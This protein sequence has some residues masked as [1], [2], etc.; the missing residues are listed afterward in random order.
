M[1]ARRGGRCTFPQL[2]QAARG[3]GAP[4][5]ANTIFGTPHLGW[6]RSLQLP[7]GEAGTLAFAACV[8][9]IFYQLQPY[10]FEHGMDDVGPQAC[11]ALC[12]PL[13]SDHDERLR[14]AHPLCLFPSICRGGQGGRGGA[15][16]SVN[17]QQLFEPPRQATA[18]PDDPPELPRATQ[19]V[20]GRRRLASVDSPHSRGAMRHCM[21]GHSLLVAIA[22]HGNGT[23]PPSIGENPL[24]QKPITSERA[25]AAA[26]LYRDLHVSLGSLAH[27]ASVYGLRV[28]VDLALS[29]P[30]PSSFTVP[31]ALV[32]N[33]TVHPNVGVELTGMY[34]RRF[35]AEAHAGTFDW[36]SVADYDLNVTSQTLHA[37]CTEHLKLRHHPELLPSVVL[38]ERSQ[39]STAQLETHVAPNFGV[40]PH[41]VRVQ[42]VHG[43]RYMVLRNPYAA[44]WLL[45]RTRFQQLLGQLESAGLDW[46]NL[47][48]PFWPTWSETGLSYLPTPP[49]E[50]SG[51]AP[52]KHRGSL[53][54]TAHKASYRALYAGGWLFGFL[55]RGPALRAVV[56]RETYAHHLVHHQTD[57][58]ARDTTLWV[59]KRRPPPQIAELLAEADSLHAES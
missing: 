14:A 37:L 26:G 12:D 58:Y 34:R 7:A 41:V 6:C 19:G 22:A 24:K 21:R 59:L 23:A 16:A 30:L 8:S 55:P 46:L 48:Q 40:A 56:P 54:G 47:P 36:F 32:V 25:S 18:P 13:A 4:L 49:S 57:L 1:A 39:N 28:H 35:Q 27:A 33:A 17:A 52:R 42:A 3:G 5:R 51:K 29:H 31:P 53:A 10:I 45:P 15:L 44:S 20:G 11:A 43:T 2:H 50:P 38:Y 9:G